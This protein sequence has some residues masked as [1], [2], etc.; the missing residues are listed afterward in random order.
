M[1]SLTT[2]VSILGAT[3]TWIAQS[4]LVQDVQKQYRK[5]LFI[6]YII[7]GS[8]LVCACLLI[9]H[10]LLRKA[11]AGPIQRVLGIPREIRWKLGLMF[12]GLSALCYICG[13][14]Y[15]VS[16]N[17]TTVPTNT[18][19]YQLNC[20]FVFLI[21]VCALGERSNCAKAG[22]VLTCTLG[23][24][25]VVWSGRTGANHGKDTVEGILM[26]LVATI[27]YAL[28]ACAYEMFGRFMERNGVKSNPKT[29]P[30][31]FLFFI[32]V[33]TYVTL[34]PALVAAHYTGLETFELPPTTDIWIGILQNAVLEAMFN[35]FLVVG[36]A[37]SSA[38]LMS[39][40]TQLSV[41]VAYVADVIRNG[42][43][44]TTMAVVGA[45][46]LSAGFIALEFYRSLPDPKSV[47]A[48]QVED[49][50]AEEHGLLSPEVSSDEEQED[51]QGGQ[52]SEL[53]GAA[54]AAGDD[55]HSGIEL[56]DLGG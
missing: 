37:S 11:D 38:V 21:A 5:P 2:V 13:L 6:A 7:R 50:D 30:A 23:T 16:L 1:L 8:T 49:E 12:A 41:P 47:A 26:T 19:L 55:D 34:W 53:G 33:C 42:Y 29:D 48:R 4:E 15:Y 36:I 25:L 24:A 32:G 35:A 14:A 10:A 43:K 54:V 9:P 3:L 17:G 28:Y 22:A 46:L 45:L 40:G 52:R 18:A 27:T 44:I 56:Q 51:E 31:L 39:A 20:V